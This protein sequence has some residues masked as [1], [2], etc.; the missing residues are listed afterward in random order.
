MIKKA[1]NAGADKNRRRRRKPE[2]AE[3]EILDAAEQFL[4]EHSFRQM[5]IDD[6]MSGTGLSR[7]SFYEY[8]RDRSHLVIRLNDR[9]QERNQARSA[10]WFG[11]QNP[12]ADLRH[13]TRELVEMYVIDG[14]L[15]RAL[16]EAA[17]IDAKVEAT[18]QITFAGIIEAVAQ[19]IN[20]YI[21]AG[22]TQLDGLDPA[23]IAAA[24]LWMNERY[25]LERLGRRPQA[26]A[27]VVT[28]TLVAIWERVLHGVSR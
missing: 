26:D 11:G 15:M 17:Q 2:D 8:F 24:L 9:L 13:S 21:A 10:R 16:W 5:T 27:E 1:N 20:E 12:V 28:N 14:H 25:M 22:A 18:F 23:E 4:R 7:P 19:R 6:I 3:S